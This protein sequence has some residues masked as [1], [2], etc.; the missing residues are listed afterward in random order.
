MPLVSRALNSLGIARRHSHC[1]KASVRQA[2]S[3]DSGS[4]NLETM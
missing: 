2:G 3:I 1:F 4:G